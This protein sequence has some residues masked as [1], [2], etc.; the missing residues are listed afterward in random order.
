MEITASVQFACLFEKLRFYFFF[1]TFTTEWFNR[2]FYLL[3]VAFTEW[4]I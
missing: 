1:V 3:W 2:A 4:L